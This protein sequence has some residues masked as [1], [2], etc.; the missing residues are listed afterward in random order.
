MPNQAFH[1]TGP[2]RGFARPRLLQRLR[3]VSLVVSRIRYKEA[4]WVHR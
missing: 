4:K 2:Q 1:L 3:Q